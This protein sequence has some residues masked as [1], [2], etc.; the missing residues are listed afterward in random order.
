MKVIVFH[1]RNLRSP[2]PVGAVHPDV[3]KRFDIFPES[4]VL[5]EAKTRS[6]I[7]WIHSNTDVPLLGNDNISVGLSKRT[8]K[9]MEVK[10]GDEI[11]LLIPEF[12][13]LLCQPALIDDLPVENEVFVS[14]VIRK[15]VTN[16]HGWALLTANGLD[17]PVRPRVRNM[18]DDIIR[19]SILMR[20]FLQVGIQ[21]ENGMV[22]LSRIPDKENL[23]LEIRLKRNSIIARKYGVFV[24]FCNLPLR[25]IQQMIEWVLRPLLLA[26]KILL[27]TSEAPIG[28][29]YRH[30]VR[31]PISIFPLLGISAGDQIILNWAGR[32]VIAI[33]LVLSEADQTHHIDKSI[34]GVDLYLEHQIEKIPNHL[35]M[36]VSASIRSELGIP[37]YSVLSVRRR[38]FTIVTKKINQL[39]LPIGGLVLMGLA[40]PTLPKS[41]LFIGL[42]LVVFFSFLPDRYQVPPTGR[43]P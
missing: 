32:Q 3:L 14:P 33:A 30:I 29:D 38:L 24:Y 6:A 2:K 17:I 7:V 28:D 8:I 41:I 37:R 10:D 36:K 40:V 19:M 27:E 9:L 13:K 20:V 5:L 21:T 43:W 25:I 18:N 11:D 42:L 35:K 26:P 15:L 16:S 34:Q 1:I 23:P 12:K 4:Q 22:Q 39:I 31:M